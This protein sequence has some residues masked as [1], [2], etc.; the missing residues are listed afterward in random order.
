MIQPTDAKGANTMKNLIMAVT[1][2]AMTVFLFSCENNIFQTVRPANDKNFDEVM[3]RGN[4][5]YA[6]AN[7]SEACDWYSK[8]VALNPTNSDAHYDYAKS[9]M[10]LHN[11]DS[12][13]LMLQLYDNP[14]GSTPSETN[15]LAGFDKAEILSM[16]DGTD[17]AQQQIKQIVDGN[18]TTG[19]I[20]ATD[21]SVDYAFVLALKSMSLIFKTMDEVN[22][23]VDNIQFVV[24]ESSVSISDWNNLTPEKQQEIIDEV[25]AL[26][27]DATAVIDLL[28]S[29]PDQKQAALDF[30]DKLKNI[31]AI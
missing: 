25:T 13:G 29:D 31:G 14:G 21:V 23:L 1:M 10:R 4:A 27:D 6:A 30:L 19:K 26:A 22:A 12:I 7:W 16:Y 28:I 18:C 24:N 11:V 17:E 9:L 2:A 3:S 8:A 5:A 20:K 15:V